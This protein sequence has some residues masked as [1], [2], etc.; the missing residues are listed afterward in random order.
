[1]ERTANN[2]QLFIILGGILAVISLLTVFCNFGYSYEEFFFQFLEIDFDTYSSTYII[3]TIIQIIAKVLLIITIFAF[4]KKDNRLL[5]IPYFGVAIAEI[6]S[7]FTSI[8]DGYNV[9]LLEFTPLIV[10]IGIAV[11]FL[12]M[13]TSSSS[14]DVI[15]IG[16]TIS[17]ILV[18]L[19]TVTFNGPYSFKFDYGYDISFY[20]ISISSLLSFVSFIGAAIFIGLSERVDVSNT[21]S[22][23]NDSQYTYRNKFPQEK[24]VKSASTKKEELLK[25]LDELKESGLLSE[26]EYI[27]KK[28]S[29]TDSNNNI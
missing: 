13:N 27:S 15:T 8:N 21:H 1:M 17:I 11:L 3:T 28:N 20:Y 26:E 23:Q 18:I 12:T 19:L 24:V 5:S 9:S 7:L 6:I 25:N 4:M 14:K 29:L 2:K 16:G 10:Y 22:S